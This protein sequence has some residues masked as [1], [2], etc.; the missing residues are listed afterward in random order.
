MASC[1]EKKHTGNGAERVF[2]KF[3]EALNVFYADPGDDQDEQK[4]LQLVED[5]FVMFQ[6]GEQDVSEEQIG[7]EKS[8]QE[9]GDRQTDYVHHVEEMERMEVAAAKH[10]NLHR[11]LAEEEEIEF[12]FKDTIL[13]SGICYT[14]TRG[15]DQPESDQFPRSLRGAYW[16]PS[17]PSRPPLPILIPGSSL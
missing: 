3:S 1:C 10:C 5:A 9:T 14:A 6:E 11:I 8:L 7:G 2:F 4:Q 15:T 17:S 12:F 16:V 13:N